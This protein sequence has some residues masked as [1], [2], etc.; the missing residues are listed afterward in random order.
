MQSVY[1]GFVRA[2]HNR[3]SG[4]IATDPP[5]ALTVLPR[6]NTLMPMALSYM[7]SGGSLITSSAAQLIT[8]AILARSL[9]VEQFG[10]FVAI[11][12]ITSVA[13]QLCGLGSLDCLVRRVARDPAMY[14]AML[15][16]TIILSAVTGLLLVGIGIAV[17]P[18]LF[19]LS[20]DPVQST[21]AIALLLSAN[22]LLARII[23]SVEQV[24]IAHSRFAPANRNVVSYAIGRL[25]AAG[26]GCLV[27]GVDNLADWALWNFAAHLLIAASSLLA[28]RVLGRPR[29]TIVREEIRLGLLFATPFILRALRQNTDLLVLT[30]FTSP[31]IVGS[32]SV[33]RRIFESGFLSVE[34]LN[35]LI[36]P[37]SAAITADGLHHVMDRVK[38]VLVAALGISTF[39]AVA[40]FVLAP[41]LPHLFGHDYVSLV[42]FTRIICWLVIVMAIYGVALEALGA[43]GLQQA[44]AA[45]L[46]GASVL[47]GM[48]IA[49]ATWSFGISGTFGAVYLTEIG[50]AIAAWLVLLH[51]ARAGARLATKAAG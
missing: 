5:V 3:V 24:F 28:V 20:P 11:T 12:A 27:F 39:T 13:L 45:V 35:R 23:L 38:Q 22:I 8:F 43:S 42:P 4:T 9:G 36:Y 29:L 7:A 26:L 15:G 14:P 50:T 6:L 2:W 37:G 34:A 21:L 18:F 19:I 51:L 25:T 46:N 30:A 33:A 16:H 17:L 40:I 44:R 10:L 41:L 1:R 32:Y 47:G 49:W 48:L 31:E